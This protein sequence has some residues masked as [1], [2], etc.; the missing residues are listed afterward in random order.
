[1]LHRD[2]EKRTG[3]T[4]DVVL[5][6]RPLEGKQLDKPESRRAA[7]ISA[8]ATFALVAGLGA[9]FSSGSEEK[10]DAKPRTVDLDTL[11]KQAQEATVHVNAI[12]EPEAEEE[13][14]FAEPRKTVDPLQGE[15]DEILGLYHRGSHIKAHHQMKKLSQRAPQNVAVAKGLVVTARGV[16]AWGEAYDA[17]E[18]WLKMTNSSEAGVAFAR[19]QKA[20]L[21]GNPISTLNKVLETDPEYKPAIDLLD[22]YEEKKVA[23][24]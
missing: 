1:M 22:K 9:V 10:T 19:L 17:A 2:A 13:L 15:V 12:E 7:L 11:V 4:K 20:T 3:T 6:L 21:R 24:R 16:K 8:A 14:E 5:A 23:A 18:F